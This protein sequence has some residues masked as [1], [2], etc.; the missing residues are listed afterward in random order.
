ML[1]HIPLRT[2]STLWVVIAL[3]IGVLIS[4]IWFYSERAWQEHLSQAYS[5]G[6][7][8]FYALET[9]QAVNGISLTRLAGTD[10][11]NAE[12]GLFERISGAPR[13]AYITLLSM[14]DEIGGAIGSSSSKIAVVSDRLQY[15]VADIVSGLM[16][17]LD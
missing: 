1:S 2:L 15:K 14:P 6:V 5:L 11:K 13:P 12:L 16:K 8:N 9:G 3:G 10:L 7:E 4:A 17:P